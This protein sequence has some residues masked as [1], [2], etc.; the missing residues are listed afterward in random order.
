VTGAELASLPLTP[1]LSGYLAAWG[2]YPD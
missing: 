2:V 1:G